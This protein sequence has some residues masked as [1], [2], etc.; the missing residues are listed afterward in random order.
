MAPA[1]VVVEVAAEGR[2]VFRLS[3]DIGREG[4]RLVYPAPFEAGRPVA[5]RLRL[6][7]GDAMLR[8]EARVEVVGDA[9]ERESAPEAEQE[10]TVGGCG[11]RFLNPSEATQL[12]ITRYVS[13][14]LGIPMPPF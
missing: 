5:V 7:D 10:A 11:L 2:R 13:T 3:R 1:A 14:R 6:P 9:P 12:A 4:L 8:L